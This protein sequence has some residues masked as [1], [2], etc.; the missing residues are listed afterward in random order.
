MSF[1]DRITKAKYATEMFE[2]WCKMHNI[3]SANSGYEELKQTNNFMELIKKL[4]TK[5]ANRVRYFPDKICILNECKL[6]EIKNSKYI[7]REAYQTY[8]DL[9]NIGYKCG[10]VVLVNEKLLFNDIC[11]VKLEKIYNAD[12]PIESNTWICP[13]QF[14]D[15]TYRKWKAKHSNASGTDFGKVDFY[16]FIELK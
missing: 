5:T 11:K 13:R 8:I 16:N 14:P 3:A 2:K 9:D 4:D 15:E 10:I 1:E 7:E 6:I 12:A